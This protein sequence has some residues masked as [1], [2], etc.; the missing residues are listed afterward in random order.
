MTTEST[1]TPADELYARELFGRIGRRLVPVLL[2]AFVISYIDRVNVGFAA[3]TA[4]K[5]LGMSAADFGFGAGLFFISYMIF[6]APSNY[7]LERVGARLWLARIMICCGIVSAAMFWVSNK[8]QFNIA[9]FT[10]G[11]VEAGLFPGVVL[12]LTWWFPRRFRARYIS[13]F[14]VG[15]PLSSVIGSPVSGLLLNMDGILG[16]KG[17]QWLYLIEALPAFVVGVLIWLLLADHPDQ[18]AWLTPAERDFVKRELAR[19]RAGQPERTAHQGSLLQQLRLLGDG[20]VILFAL[21]FFGTGVPSYGLGLWLPQIVNDFGL[22]TVQT[23]LI[24]AVPFLCGSIAM[25]VWGRRSDRR[26]ERIWHTVAAAW[27]AAAGLAACYWIEAP[28]VALAALSVAAAGI[29]AVKG[30][31]LSAVSESF[32]PATAAVGIALVS[33]LGN[34]SGQFAP[35]MVGVIRDATGQFQAGLLALGLCSLAGGALLLLRLRTPGPR[36]AAV[37]RP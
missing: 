14:A 7:L 25:I 28:L 5:D 29:Y 32:S 18:A 12:Y 19:D 24:S 11:V 16:F 30:P 20:R 37:A 31:F 9:R 2:A 4:S 36:P 17:W 13:M 15:I 22:S 3:I 23:G 33:S 6:E 1:L 26:G 10:L 27:V 8:T 35:W 21:V 34:L